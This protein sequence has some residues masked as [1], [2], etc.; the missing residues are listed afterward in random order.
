MT[1]PPTGPVLDMHALEWD[2][3]AGLTRAD[4]WTCTRC[5]AAAL[6]YLGNVYGSA[7]T[8]SCTRQETP[9]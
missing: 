5:G 4:R 6:N 2:P 8:E 9:R 3:P 1:Q 7:T